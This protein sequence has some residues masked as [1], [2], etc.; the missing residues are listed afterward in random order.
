M[1][2]EAAIREC[3]VALLRRRAA[4]A[5][6]CPSEVAR[7]LAPDEAEWRASMPQVRRVAA[8]MAESG[9]VGVTQGERELPSSEV[10]LA[11]GPIRLRRSRG[12]PDAD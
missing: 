1:A 4:D 11:S 8:A 12:F 2:D 7:A 6:I 3:I 5:S 10:V 9:E